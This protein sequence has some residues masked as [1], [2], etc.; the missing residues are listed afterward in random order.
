[1]A[2]IFQRS[3]RMVE[4]YP[5]YGML[6]LAGFMVTY[7]AG[8]HIFSDAEVITY[9][10]KRDYTYI[11]DESSII[12]QNYLGGLYGYVHRHYGYQQS[13]WNENLKQSIKDQSKDTY[14]KI[15][16]VGESNSKSVRKCSSWD[17]ESWI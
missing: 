9:P 16:N 1:M 11:F 17:I 7:T 13:L 14:Q 2:S 4:N 3:L 6:G 15:G 8:R 12:N 5:L 10:K